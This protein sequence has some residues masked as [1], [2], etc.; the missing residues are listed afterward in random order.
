MPKKLLSLS[1]ASIFATSMYIHC[2]VAEE[3]RIPVGEQAKTQAA[4]DMP[5]KGMSKERVKSLFGE[6]LEEVPA[7]GQPPI[8][9]WRYQE[10][11]VYFDSNTVIHCVRNFQPKA[12]TPESD[13]QSPAQ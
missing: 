13:T 10:F 9:R 12:S 11:T 6:A 7:K 1:I 8:S 3:I 4:I 2:S 5:S